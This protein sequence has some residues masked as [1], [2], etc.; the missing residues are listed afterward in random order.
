[1]RRDRKDELDLLTS[2]ERRTRPH[3]GEAEAGG[4]AQ[5]GNQSHRCFLSRADILAP[6]DWG[7]QI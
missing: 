7:A 2:E 3:R 6:R 5:A 1:M 4:E